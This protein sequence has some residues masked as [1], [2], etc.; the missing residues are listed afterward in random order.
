MKSNLI[1]FLPIILFCIS[2]GK[3]SVTPINEEIS[4]ASTFS[5][6]ICLVTNAQADPAFTFDMPYIDG[7]KLRLGWRNIEQ[8][9]NVYDWSLIDSYVEEARTR[10]KYLSISIAG[11]SASPQWLIAMLEPS[12]YVIARGNIVPNLWNETYVTEYIQFIEAFGARYVNEKYVSHI[13]VSGIGYTNEPVIPPPFGLEVLEE[14]SIS[15][16]RI[17][18]AYIANFPA[19]AISIPIHTQISTEDTW[20]FFKE[21]VLN[22]TYLKSE[23][24]GLEYHGLDATASSIEGTIADNYYQEIKDISEFRTTGYQFV[25]STI[26]NSV[27]DPA[28]VNGSSQNTDNLLQRTLEAGVI[29]GADFIEV[30]ANDASDPTNLELFKSISTLLKE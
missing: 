8:S 18:D 22:P 15:S 27:C 7:V 16:N 5:G 4:T 20:D 12:E 26:G 2:C 1:L 6:I 24:I 14:W 28:W 13:T 9:N 23:N 30:Y 21:H 11:G 29:N 19:K 17:I 3:D 10:D 25:C